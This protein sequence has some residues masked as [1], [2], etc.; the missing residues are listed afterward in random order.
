MTILTQ[1]FEILGPRKGKNVHVRDGLVHQK[2]RTILI[3]K[4]I[5]YKFSCLDFL[6][7]PVQIDGFE[8]PSREPYFAVIGVAEDF[9]PKS[10]IKFC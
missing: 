6:L 2:F 1:S 3:A 5:S 9:Q 8:S 7:H 4:N 10:F